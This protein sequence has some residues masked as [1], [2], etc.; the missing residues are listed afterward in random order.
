MRMINAREAMQIVGFEK[1]KFYQMVANKE[2]PAGKRVG[3][4]TRWPDYIVQG[5]A[6]QYW[7]LDEPMPEMAESSLAEIMT[8][9]AKVRALCA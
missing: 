7:G 3:V 6:I 5:Y 1:T 9:V 4:S 2:F 8:C